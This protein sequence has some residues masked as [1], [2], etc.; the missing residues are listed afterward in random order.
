MKAVFG[1]VFWIVTGMTFA[2][3]AQSVRIKWIVPDE[4]EYTDKA[5]QTE[6]S[7]LDVRVDITSSGGVKIQPDQVRIFRNGQPY[8][9]PG[10]K[11]GNVSLKQ[12]SSSDVRLGQN[13]QLIEG[14]NRWEVEVKLPNQ[15]PVR[16][17]LL[18]VNWLSGKPNLYIVCAG[19]SSNLA[20]TQN[21]AKAVFQLF[22]SQA[23]HLF[24][25]VEGILLV[26]KDRTDRA[27]MGTVLEDLKN[28]G[29]RPQDVLIV[30]FSGHGQ[31]GAS[32]F[33]LIG[34]NNTSSLKYSLLNYQEDIIMN[35]QELSC[36]RLIL[37]DACHSGAALG[38]KSNDL[39]QVQDAISKTPPQIIT[40]SSSSGDETSFE[41]KAWEHGAFTKVL[42]EGLN[43][44]ADK[45]PRNGSVTVQELKDY[46]VDEVPLL[47]NQ[48]L[49]K[50]QHPRLIQPI[51]HDFA[52]FNYQH[53][54]PNVALDNEPCEPTERPE[55][56][57]GRKMV[58]VGLKANPKE[59]DYELSRLTKEQIEKNQQG[60]FQY[61]PNAKALELI[62]T[63]AAQQVANGGSTSHKLMPSGLDAGY[64][65]IISRQ[66]TTYRQETEAGN[67]YWVAAVSLNCYVVSAPSGDVIDS[68]ALNKIG[69]DSD[70]A[71]AEKNAIQ[72]AIAAL[73]KFD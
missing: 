34:S 32:G 55:P 65:C 71:E 19:I 7:S 69:A 28:R 14:E 23:G 70:K 43:G 68:Y 73:K 12:T 67:T 52:I 42:L 9:R 39:Q 48:Q 13:L 10:E 50:P 31:V 26:C 20:Y 44:K 2:A 1:I 18:T 27:F 41:D 30:F 38:M 17:K 15:R 37:M 33:G 49:K 22:K 29:L 60:V 66:P 3:Q 40:I 6:K 47:V 4:V 51:E 36:K 54:N 21:D 63:G 57:T 11:L 45:N 5:Y 35:L 24:G 25:S 53:R 56:T 64:I 72:Q 62:R 58:I 46:L 16:S 8:S 59:L 61:M